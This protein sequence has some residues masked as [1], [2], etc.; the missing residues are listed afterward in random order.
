MERHYQL[1]PKIN[2]SRG[3][4]T[5]LHVMSLPF[6]KR[7]N[8]AG[9]TDVRTDHPV[10]VRASPSSSDCIRTTE[11]SVRPR[12]ALADAPSQ[13]KPCS[14]VFIAAAPK[15]RREPLVQRPAQREI[16]IFFFHFN[17]QQTLSSLADFRRF[18]SRDRISDRIFIILC[19]VLCACV[20]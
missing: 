20:F 4:E 6:P 11:R 1:F 13:N 14:S 17:S 3:Q 10:C 18:R 8:I 7:I 2:L 16:L 9:C 19:V 5:L 12:P 15:K